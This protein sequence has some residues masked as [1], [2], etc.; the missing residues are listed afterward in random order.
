MATTALQIQE[1]VKSEVGRILVDAG[2]YVPDS[3]GKVAPIQRGIALGAK[4]VGMLTADALAVSDAELAALS[5]FAIDWVKDVATHHVLGLVVN[6]NWYRVV[7]THMEAVE[8]QRADGG[9]LAEQK[10]GIKAEYQRLGSKLA[11]GFR[12][13]TDPVSVAYSAGYGACTP[14][15]YPYADPYSL[16]FAFSDGRWPCDFPYGYRIWGCP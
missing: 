1:L 3:G 13:T 6:L 4:S 16:A 10:L 15:G 9:W 14:G 8:P 7:Q 11:E 2:L 5:P 12:E